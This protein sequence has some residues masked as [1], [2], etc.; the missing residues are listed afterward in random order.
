MTVTFR[1]DVGVC[2]EQTDMWSVIGQP[3]CTA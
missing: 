2:V 3:K 1:V